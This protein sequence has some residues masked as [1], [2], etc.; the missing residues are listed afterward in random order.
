MAPNPT[1]KG[2][3]MATT[4]YTVLTTEGVLFTASK[5]AKAVAFADENRGDLEIIVATG[6]GTIVHTVPPIK[7]IKMSK[8]YTRVVAVPEGVEVPSDL[9]V[10]YRK[11]RK[12]LTVLHDMSKLGEDDAY[13]VRDDKTGKTL[14]TFPSPRDC[15][16]F[17]TDFVREPATV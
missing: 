14:A 4:T 17:T 10:C 9:R 8:P 13:T 6:T 15:G 12:G 11:S 2:T 1:T 16:R 3:T 5:K 7:R